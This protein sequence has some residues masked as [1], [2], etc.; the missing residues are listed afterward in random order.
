MLR[1]LNYSELRGPS[2]PGRPRPNIALKEEVVDPLPSS[3]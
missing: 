2:G 1:H 3:D